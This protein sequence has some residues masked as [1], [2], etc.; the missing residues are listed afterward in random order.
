MLSY[1]SS[2]LGV[3]DKDKHDVCEICFCAK[4]T[5]GKFALSENKAECVFELIH[6]DIW[7]PYGVPS[8][9][10]AY[11]FSTIVDDVSRVPWAYLMH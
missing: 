6:Y 10:G 2:S 9:S 1:F 3:F 11:Y 8:S 7:G 5:R 4:Q